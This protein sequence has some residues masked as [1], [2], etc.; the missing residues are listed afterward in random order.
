MK[1]LYT[2]ASPYARKVR[3]LMLEKGIEDVEFAVV[4]PFDQPDTLTAVNPLSKI[5]TLILD[6]GTVLF[7]STVI[8]EYL[9]VS[10]KS[11]V[12]FFPAD[13][14][15][16]WKV[17]RRHALADGLM[18]LCV[19]LALETLRRE[20]SLRSPG[21][22]EHLCGNMRRAVNSIEVEIDDFGEQLNI[23]HLALASA[24]GYLDARAA[25]YV[26]WRAENPKLDTWFAEFGNRPSMLATVPPT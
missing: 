26:P 21:W 16:R 20:E 8:C 22:I 24:L 19:G 18:D 17:A 6:E 4:N 25:K 14:A 10:R 9:D 15:L 5:P 2:P 7:D 11:A 1:L 23:S 12:T 13:T 3:L